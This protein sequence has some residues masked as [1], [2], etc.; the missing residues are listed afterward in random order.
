MRHTLLLVGTITLLASSLWAQLISPPSPLRGHFL[1]DTIEIGRPFRYALT[2]DHAPTI[3][4]LFPDTARSFAPYLVKEVTVFT[5]RTTGVGPKAISR[6]SAVYT[7]TSFKTD[8]VQ[9]L[10]VPIRLINPADCTVLLTNVDTVFL[11]S[12]LPIR[13]PELTGLRS[14]SLARE[15]TVTSLRQQ[16][17][18]PVLGVVIF[19]LVGISLLAYGLF[20]RVIR[21]Q[22]RLYQLNRQHVRFLRDYKRLIE[23]INADSATDTANQAI[24]AW[25]IYLEKLERKPYASLTTSEIADR[26]SDERVTKALREA[27]QMIY[28]G[29]FSAQSQPALRVLSEVATQTYTRRRTLLQA[30]P[31]KPA[32][33][34]LEPDETESP[35]LSA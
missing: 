28:G 3:D 25:K 14:F 30:L 35:T 5:T 34:V 27:D 2:Y 7:L 16:F 13:S 26:M 8:S 21:R 4:V 19:A 15:T 6:D 10:Q 24:I 20:G 1:S 12:K 32:G 18:Y 33:D 11:R 17:N 9:L 22:W 23:G 29:G 31:D